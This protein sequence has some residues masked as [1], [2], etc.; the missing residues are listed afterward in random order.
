M[1]YQNHQAAAEAMLFVYGEPLEIKR[2]AGLLSIS[3]EEAKAAVANLGKSLEDSQ[4]GL[5]LLFNN[6]RVQLATKK[7]FHSL[8][9]ALIKSEFEENLTPAALETLSVVVYLGP[10]SRPKIDYIRGVNSSYTVRNLMLRGL[11]ERVS[12]GKSGNAFLYQASFDLL[13]HLGISRISELPDYGKYKELAEK[14]S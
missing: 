10:V 4:R 3:E 8:A 14:T 13:K 12:D 5:T 1:D 9:E 2:M 6:N 7:E 11:I